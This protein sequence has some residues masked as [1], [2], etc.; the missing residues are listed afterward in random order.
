MLAHNHRLHTTSLRQASGPF[1][2]AEVLAAHVAAGR[3]PQLHRL[4]HVEKAGHYTTVAT[5]RPFWLCGNHPSPTDTRKRTQ[6]A[7]SSSESLLRSVW[8]ACGVV[9]HKFI[10][11][12]RLLLRGKPHMGQHTHAYTTIKC[13]RTH[14]HSDAHSTPQQRPP[15]LVSALRLG[16]L[17]RG[18]GHERQRVQPA[19]KLLVEQLHACM[20]RRRWQE[21][22]AVTR[23][24]RLGPRG[25]GRPW[26]TRARA[27]GMRH[28]QYGAGVCRRSGTHHLS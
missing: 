11:S 18:L 13:E 22:A 27:H 23:M 28:V 3:G 7:S 9:F 6:P 10:A 19:G 12:D 2:Q 5:T 16:R 14:I 1:E 21:G 4:F 25:H 24:S 15:A 26:S 17:G 8:L 20:Q